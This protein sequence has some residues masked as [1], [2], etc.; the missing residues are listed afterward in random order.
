MS[1]SSDLSEF[2]IRN[3]LC[4]SVSSV[5]TNKES[6]HNYLTFVYQPLFNTRQI[7]SLLELGLMHGASLLLW[8][9]YLR[10]EICVGIDNGKL[11]RNNP[12]HLAGSKSKIIIGNAFSRSIFTNLR[13]KFD[14]I[15][16]DANHTLYQQSRTACLYTKKLSTKGVLIIE[17]VM[18]KKNY[19]NNIVRSLPINSTF[20]AY[21]I[22]LTA[23][24]PKH[25]LSSC[26]LVAQAGVLNPTIFEVDCTKLSRPNTLQRVIFYL[27]YRYFLNPLRR[28]NSSLRYRVKRLIKIIH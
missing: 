10:L 1:F 21:H 9:K 15:I 5:G 11:L 25:P 13:D 24:E 28:L 27:I 16:D 19:L 17:D 18:M 2:C 14:I 23:L 26:V 3:N 6:D 20:E 7:K 8:E 22:D 12:L 4:S